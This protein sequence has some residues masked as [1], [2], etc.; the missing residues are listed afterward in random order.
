VKHDLLKPTNAD[1]S[2]PVLK[3]QAAELALARCAI[4][5]QV[6]PSPRRFVSCGQSEKPTRGFEPRTPSLRVPPEARRPE[7]GRSHN[8]FVMRFRLPSFRWASVH[9]VARVA[10]VCPRRDRRRFSFRPTVTMPAV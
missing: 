6:A 1:E 2:Q 8:R 10:P 7:A 3:L 4:P 9:R 5:V